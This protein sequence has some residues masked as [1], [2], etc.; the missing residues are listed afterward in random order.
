MTPFSNISD[1]SE[2]RMTA[3][4][5]VVRRAFQAGEGS[6]FLVSVARSLGYEVSARR[7]W[8]D[9]DE[10]MAR[11]VA[12][13]ADRLMSRS[14][15]SEFPVPRDAGRNTVTPGAAAFATMAGSVH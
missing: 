8:T 5:P 13:R 9:A 11:A 7:G 1:G 4:L 10:Q 2:R 6:P 15:R 3:L 14:A 12:R